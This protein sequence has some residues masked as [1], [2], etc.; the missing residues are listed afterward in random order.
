M[1]Q[2]SL[3]TTGP[4]ATNFSEEVARRFGVT[5]LYL[6]LIYK[7]A[8]DLQVNHEEPGPT[9][10]EVPGAN[11]SVKSK[12]FGECSVDEMRKAIQRKRKPASSKPLPEEDL[13]LAT[14]LEEAV[15]SR[16]SKGDNVRVSVRNEKDKAVMTFDGIPLEQVLKLAEALMAPLPAVNE[17]K[18][19][20]KPF[21]S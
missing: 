19:A 8:A 5:C 4:V 9:I 10:I 7:E 13:M 11:G 20:R 16:F 15:T 21:V 18:A 17:L 3:T 12:T 2:A 6:L 14:Q 1:S